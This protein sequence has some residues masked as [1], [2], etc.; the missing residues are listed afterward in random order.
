MIVQAIDE[1][2]DD[3]RRGSSFYS[4]LK[5]IQ[6]VHV[7]HCNEQD[8]DDDRTQTHTFLPNHFEKILVLAL[9]SLLLQGHV[10]P[11]VHGASSI[12]CFY[13]LSQALKR[14]R[15]QSIARYLMHET[16]CRN[17][18]FHTCQYQPLKNRVKR[19][20]FITKCKLSDPQ[21]LTVTRSL[22]FKDSYM[23]LDENT[24]HK[25]RGRRYRQRQAH[26]LKTQ[27][28]LEKRATKPGVIYC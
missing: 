15:I 22:I 4:I 8:Q 10:V 17:R 16:S 7:R 5:Y 13:K 20:I 23:E 18:L 14:K 11:C 25:T 24:K 26:F 9:N 6:A 19:K 3:V 12:T 27:F 2:Q 1:L 21:V 28:H